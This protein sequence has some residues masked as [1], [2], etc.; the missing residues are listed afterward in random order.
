MNISNKNTEQRPKLILFAAMILLC[1]TAAKI[2]TKPDFTGKWVINLTKSDFGSSPQYV[3]PRQ[4]EITQTAK[5]LEM[6]QTVADNFGQ[7][8]TMRVKLWLDGKSSTEMVTAD[9]RTRFYRVSWSDDWQV[10]KED[11]SSS[12]IN[13]LHREEYH[14]TE[15]WKLTPDAKQLLLDKKVQQD[16]GGGYEVKV[17][18]DKK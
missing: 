14:T 4:L 2:M 13:D 18:Y 11:Y 9:H 1:L 7:D 16:N 6:K 8:S 3:A 12:F 10:L 17:T 15:E 5:Y